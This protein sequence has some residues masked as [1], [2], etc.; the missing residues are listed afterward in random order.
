MPSPF[1]SAAVLR[2]F[3][4]TVVGLRFGRIDVVFLAGGL[5]V[6]AAGLYAIRALRGVDRSPA[7]PETAVPQDLV[8]TSAED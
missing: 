6:V 8:T 3:D 2:G 5:L 4:V 7:E 1:R